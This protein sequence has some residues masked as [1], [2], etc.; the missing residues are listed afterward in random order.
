MAYNLSYIFHVFSK[1]TLF[2]FDK[3]SI[4]SDNGNNKEHKRN[5]SDISNDLQL[6]TTSTASSSIKQ[7][8]AKRPLVCD[9]DAALLRKL[10]VPL[11]GYINQIET[12]IKSKPG[13]QCSLH[14]FLSTHVRDTFLAKGH[15]RTLE[16]TI[17]SLS[18]N[19][20]AWRTII[21]PEEMKAMGLS[22]P[23]LQ[24]TVLFESRKFSY[25]SP[26]FQRLN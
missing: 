26:R 19:Q 8:R 4:S 11:I 25:K 24:S 17:E 2:K 1:K 20:D 9:P 21:T 18:K 22:R 23:L 13:Q 10:Y 14:A 15:N 6:I 16:L 7:D 3:S 5:F 12:S